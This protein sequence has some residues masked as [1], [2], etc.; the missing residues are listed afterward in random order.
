MYEFS[1]E[2][3]NKLYYHPFRISKYIICIYELEFIATNK[4]ENYIISCPQLSLHLPYI[5]KYYLKINYSIILHCKNLPN[6]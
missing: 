6:S 2:L 4:I 3:F 1:S 5:F